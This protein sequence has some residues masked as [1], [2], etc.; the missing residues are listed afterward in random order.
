[1]WFNHAGHVFYLSRVGCG[2]VSVSGN[3]CR[4]R[5]MKLQ[6]PF[7]NPPEQ[8]PEPPCT[9][10]VRVVSL[11]SARKQNLHA[12]EV[13]KAGGAS[14]ASIFVRR[15]PKHAMRKV[16]VRGLVSRL[17]CIEH[18]QLR[19]PQRV[20][21]NRP[22][23]VR[24]FGA[25]GSCYTGWFRTND[26]HASRAVGKLMLRKHQECGKSGMHFVHSVHSVLVF[27]GSPWTQLQG[28]TF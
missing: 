9:C 12:R 1:M 14:K 8:R 25:S 15:K 17:T 21:T 11:R 16:C 3:T 10:F 26:R 13:A 27:H 2:A 22:P 28:S 5:F 6:T 19:Y 24:G 4:V 20:G 18:G 23:D 7:S